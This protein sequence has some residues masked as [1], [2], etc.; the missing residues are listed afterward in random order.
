[1]PAAARVN[2]D[3]AK[4]AWAILANLEAA[5]DSSSGQL[6]KTRTRAT[7]GLD[8]LIGKANSRPANSFVF[9]RKFFY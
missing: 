1:L 8:P 2:I 9:R 5:D 3:A 7:C 4:H 6:L